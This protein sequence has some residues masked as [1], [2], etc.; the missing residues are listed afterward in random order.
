VTDFNLML[1]GGAEGSLTHRYVEAGEQISAADMSEFN[2]VYLVSGKYALANGE[3]AGPGDL[4]QFDEPSPIA[5]T[6]A[7]NVIEIKVMSS[8]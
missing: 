2:F 3:M 4:I 7:G 1:K 8:K 6:L 5:C